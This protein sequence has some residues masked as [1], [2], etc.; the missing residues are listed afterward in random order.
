LIGIVG[1]DA[2]ARISKTS[3]DLLQS[4]G[5][6]FPP[7]ICITF[8]IVQRFMLL[9]HLHDVVIWLQLPEFISLLLYHF[10]KAQWGLD[11]NCPY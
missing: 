7:L 11:D 2:T 4:L 8:L 5:A 9:A 6:L 1:R 3:V 10:F